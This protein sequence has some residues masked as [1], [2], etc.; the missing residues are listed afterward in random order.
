M[1]PLIK[2]SPSALPPF[3][4]N[5]SVT[6]SRKR[7]FQRCTNFGGA[8]PTSWRPIYFILKVPIFRINSQV[9]VKRIKRISDLETTP[10]GNGSDDLHC[11][12]FEFVN[13][14]IGQI[15]NSSP[16][17]PPSR[18]F[19]IQLIPSTPRNF[20]FKL[21]TIPSSFPQPSPKPSTTRKPALASQISPSPI[22][23]PTNLQPVSRNSNC[24]GVE[25][26]P[27]PYPITK[28]FQL[29]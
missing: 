23:P 25:K 12:E 17:H 29:R 5:G 14:T 9:V 3:V 13:Q 8:I 1:T 22:P 2:S 15:Q 16:S 26:F 21:I 20:Q 10:Y 24:S 4:R 6:L 28:L 27:L 7:D 19:H 18:K 11:E